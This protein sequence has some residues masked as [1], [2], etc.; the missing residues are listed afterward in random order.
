MVRIFSSIAV[1][2]TLGLACVFWLGWRIGDP[3]S[4][5]SAVQGEVGLHFLAA[6]AALCFAILAHALVLTYLMGT[7]RWLEETC[8]AYRLD[9]TWQ[10]RSRELKWRL[11]PAMMAA[12]LALIGAGAFGAAAD[13]GSAVG[14]RGILGL[15]AAEVHL[16]A[17]LAAVVLNVVVNAFEYRV[18]RR[19]GELVASVLEQVRRIRVEKGLAV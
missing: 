6:V 7:G 10:Q 19:N 12:L 13:P 16:A 9:E 8:R 18:L 2:S 14:F 4:H 11:Y 15:S 1:V 17:A 5:D 3:T